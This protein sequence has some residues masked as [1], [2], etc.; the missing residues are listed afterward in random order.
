MTLWLQLFQLVSL[1]KVHY[2]FVLFVLLFEML[3]PVNLA[4][5]AEGVLNETN[6]GILLNRQY[7]AK[8]SQSLV[9][10]TDEDLAKRQ[11]EWQE[12]RRE[13]KPA[14]GT[15]YMT[16]SAYNSLANQTDASPY[17]T[18]IGSMT[19]E[20]VVASNYFPIGTRLRLPDVFGDREFRVEDRM[21]PRYFKTLDVWME[22]YTDAKSF[23]RK[24][25]KVEVVSYGKGRG[26][27]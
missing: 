2:G 3:S 8:P 5:A 12:Q 14:V 24:Y 20:G 19:R 16:A 6:S 21:N 22:N 27:E 18:A 13:T 23:G 26:V 25:V 15:V 9:L 7:I 11:T 17:R 4:T 10:L 1:A